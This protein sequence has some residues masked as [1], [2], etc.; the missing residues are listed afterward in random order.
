MSESDVVFLCLLLLSA[1]Q[2]AG[3]ILRHRLERR[4]EALEKK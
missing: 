2:V 1:G 4:I 3:A